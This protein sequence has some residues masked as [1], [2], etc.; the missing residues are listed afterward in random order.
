MHAL[1]IAHQGR[2][3]LTTGRIAL[4]APEPH[5]SRLMAVR[6]GEPNEA[7]IRAMLD[8][9]EATLRQALDKTSL[10]ERAN[11]DAID[12]FLVSAYARAW[13]GSAWVD[14]RDPER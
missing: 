12:A 1:R 5:R 6:H 13:D 7:R 8:D 3:L 9:A 2:E 14:I 10:P 11:R 4:P